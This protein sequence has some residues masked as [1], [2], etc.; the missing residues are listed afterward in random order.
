MRNLKTLGFNSDG[1]NT[2]Y[3]SN[4]RLLQYMLRRHAVTFQASILHII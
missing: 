2:F 3:T 1:L 4:I